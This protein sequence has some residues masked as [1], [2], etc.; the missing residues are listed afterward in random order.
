MR[1]AFAKELTRLAGINP[2]IVLLSGDIGNRMFDSFKE[3]AK[4]RFINC[5][6]AEANM[7][8]MAAG[9]AM[10]GLKP[11]VYTITPFTTTR[12]L[13]QIKVSVAY[14]ESPVIIV[15]TGSGLS[16]AELGPTHHSFED[17]AIT[18]SIPGI[19]VLAPSDKKELVCQLSEALE[20]K[21]PSYIRIGKKGE[22]VIFKDNS[23]LGIGKANLIKDGNEFLILTVG[24]IVS[25]AL[26]AADILSNEGISVAVATLG[27]IKPIDKNFLKKMVERGYKK[28]FT[29]EEHSVIG[30][31]GSTVLEWISDNYSKKNIDVCRLGISDSFIHEL[32][33]QNYVRSKIGIDSPGIIKKIKGI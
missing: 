23:K 30:G 31:L 3:V 25:E 7:M 2:D 6:I 29:L 21:L 17:M 32:G 19:N 22:P 12:C 4:N 18:R 33:N 26:K 16:Y 20:S 8:S 27:S 14:H 13:E 24:P 5:G 11:V 1:D 15:G 9:L 10:S 28:W